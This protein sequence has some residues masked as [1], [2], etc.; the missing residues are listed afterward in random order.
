M[1][2]VRLALPL[3]L[4]IMPAVFAQPITV[5]YSYNGLPLPIYTDAAETITVAGVFVPRSL[6]ITKV[7][8]QVQIQYPNSGDLKVYLFS[9]LGTRTILLEPIAAWSMWTQRSTIRRPHRGRISAPRR[10]AKDRSVRISRSQTSTAMILRSAPGAYGSRMTRAIAAPG[11][12]Q[13][14]L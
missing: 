13:I 4:G 11:G 3:A 6:K 1:R 12:C 10:R 7:T 2:F 9:P 8:A 14:S 5:T